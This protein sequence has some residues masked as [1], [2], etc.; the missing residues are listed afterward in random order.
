MAHQ[1][2]L[3]YTQIP[4]GVF[5]PTGPGGPTGSTGP[6]G[7]AYGE[8]GA[9]G[10]LVNFAG[11]RID[12][13]LYLNSNATTGNMAASGAGV[14]MLWGTTDQIKDSP[15]SHTN[16]T[17][18]IIINTTAWYRIQVAASFR[19]TNTTFA[20]NALLSLS[21]Q[22]DP[23]GVGSWADLTGSEYKASISGDPESNDW[24]CLSYS[25]T[26]YANLTATD[27][28]R[29][30]GIHTAGGSGVG[31]WRTGSIHMQKLEP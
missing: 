29:L 25:K 18:E 31:R 13:V 24:N 15:Y 11:D 8:I 4:D 17:A 16:N 10:D 23:L 5:A 19:N 28:I 21:I 22:R 12:S 14:A 26:I 1:P 9:T 7:G 6:A 3:N 30:W 27:E 20:N 2:Q